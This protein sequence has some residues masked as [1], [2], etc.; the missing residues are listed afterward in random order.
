MKIEEL[1]A[2]DKQKD[3]FLLLKQREDLLLDLFQQYFQSKNF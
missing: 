3:F 1:I 2:K